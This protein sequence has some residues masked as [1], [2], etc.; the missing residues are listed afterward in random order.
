MEGTIDNEGVTMERAEIVGPCAAAG[1]TTEGALEDTMEDTMGTSAIGWRM[2]QIKGYTLAYNLLTALSDEL[3]TWSEKTIY[4]GH[5][6]AGENWYMGEYITNDQT[7]S[8]A[9]S[10]KDALHCF[11]LEEKMKI[12]KRLCHNWL[13][14]RTEHG[15]ELSFIRV[16]EETNKFENLLTH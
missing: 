15:I 6:F 9:L 5:P 16:R 1:G 13:K 3:N 8:K 12:P 10:E 2:H 11:R 14:G 7:K 4:E